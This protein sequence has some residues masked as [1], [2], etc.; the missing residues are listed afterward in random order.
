MSAFTNRA[1]RASL[2]L[3]VFLGGC[4]DARESKLT[5]EWV[6]VWP[7]GKTIYRF[8]SDGYYAMESY[9]RN[10]SGI[11][12][13]GKQKYKW[14]LEG[15]KLML[16]GDPHELIALTDQ[17]LRYKNA[18]GGEFVLRPINDT[19]RQELKPQSK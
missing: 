7:G 3:L 8:E 13:E 16:G 5:R 2:V 6:W 18:A 19:D 10:A 11:Y 14:A 9:R 17:E 4:G 12:F 15:G 1:P